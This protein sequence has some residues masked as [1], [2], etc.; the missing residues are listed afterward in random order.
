MI[1]SVAEG[2]VDGTQR[3]GEHSDWRTDILFRS[4]IFFFI[5]LSYSSFLLLYMRLLFFSR[6][7][8]HHA[9]INKKVYMKVPSKPAITLTAFLQ[10]SH[11]RGYDRQNSR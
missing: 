3:L 5:I 2:E 6:S 1:F 10:I 7:M 8:D 11:G 4:L 9:P